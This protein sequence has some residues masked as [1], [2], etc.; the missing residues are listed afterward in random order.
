MRQGRP[1][2]TSRHEIAEVALGL[3]VDRGFDATTVEDIAAAVG[4][5]RRT[6]FRYFPSKNDI[7]WGD[8]GAELDRLRANL[9]AAPTD[10]PVIA[11][12]VG[13]VLATNDFRASDLPELRVRMQLMTSVP[14]L[15]A[16]STLRYQEWREEIAVFTAAR[17]GQAPYELVPQTLA[18]ATL[19]VTLAAF[20][21]WV[22]VGSSDLRPLLEEALGHLAAG[23][24]DLYP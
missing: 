17:L 3:F 8:W 1:P 20:L 22:Q 9:A 19:G 2:S 18:Y 13:A 21:R 10:V 11:A 24:A 5:G 12:V 14:T 23:F 6:L 4:I 16:Y 15:Q 7:V